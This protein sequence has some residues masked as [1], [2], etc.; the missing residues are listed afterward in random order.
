VTAVVFWP[1]WVPRLVVETF[2][3]TLAL[4]VAVWAGWVLLWLIEHR[5]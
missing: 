3:V 1:T 5:W 4:I 2:A